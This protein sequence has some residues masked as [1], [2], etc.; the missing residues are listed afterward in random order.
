MASIAAA[1]EIL[2]DGICDN[3]LEY[4]EVIQRNVTLLNN[5]TQELKLSIPKIPINLQI[6]D[7]KTWAQDLIKEVRME[8]PQ[9]A[10][11]TKLTNST[12]NGDLIQLN[13][14]LKNILAN[15]YRFSR[16]VL[17]LKF[18]EETGNL[19]IQI[20]NDGAQITKK[21]LPLV[22]E[23]FYSQNCDNSDGH[24]GLGLYVAK[25]II[26]VMDGE[27]TAKL[28]GEI[29]CFEISLPIIM[30]PNEKK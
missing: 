18:F 15:S 2:Q 27:I 9:A 5:L 7:V 28:T 6:I 1:T 30:K 13:R 17:V 11:Y 20:K 26:K 29:I 4:Y 16:N 12:I 14:A 25:Q 22:F 8:A 23:R 24:L 3:P 21:K 19:K 10:I